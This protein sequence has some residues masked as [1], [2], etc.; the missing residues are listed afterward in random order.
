MSTIV[1]LGRILDGAILGVFVMIVSG[2][3]LHLFSA[4]HTMVTITE[5]SR[6][7]VFSMLM[8]RAFPFKGDKFEYN[9]M[10]ILIFAVLTAVMSMAHHRRTE[11]LER[12]EEKVQK[13]K[14]Q[15]EKSN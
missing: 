2:F 7:G 12:E 10:H 15:K 1:A 11:R 3:A 9:L 4:F 14:K 6:L 5:K 8:S 13:E